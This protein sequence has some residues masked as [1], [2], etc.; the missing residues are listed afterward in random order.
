MRI[1]KKITNKQKAEVWGHC[2]GVPLTAKQAWSTTQG[3][4]GYIVYVMEGRSQGG[5][6]GVTE[7]G[8]RQRKKEGGRRN[9]RKKRRKREESAMFLRIRI[10]LTMDIRIYVEIYQV[11]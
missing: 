8:E 9:K 3:Q 10:R 4:T 2:A 11:K 6:E 1:K 5:R 7:E